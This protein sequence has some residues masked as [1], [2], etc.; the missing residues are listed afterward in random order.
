MPT[1]GGNILKEIFIKCRQGT[2]G[3]NLRTDIINTLLII[4]IG[5]ALGILSKLLDN[6]SL[7]DAIGWHRVLEWSD[8]GNVF[9][10]LSVWALFAVIIAVLSK[11]PLRASVNV[12]GFFS[13]MLIG[14]Y[15]ITIFISGFFPKTY[16]IAWGVI[17]LFTPVLAFFAWYS[18][19]HGW[20]AI[21]LS[22]IIIGFFFTQ[23]FSFGMYYIDIS[24]YD[25]LIC[26]LL[27]IILLY[28]DKKQ[29][30]ISLIGALIVAPLLENYLP[31]IFGG[32]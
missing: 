18:K 9:S 21:F 32:L 28:R 30:I 8:L 2:L 12:F 4:L 15:T 22:S 20:L 14:Y 10:R 19:G 23:A 6:M 29:L 7:N 11:R 24:Y 16:M 25:G 31:Y 5:S 3:K 1:E 27:V 26:L 13:G 17:T